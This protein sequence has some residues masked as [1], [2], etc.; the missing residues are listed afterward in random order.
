MSPYPNHYNDE[1]LRRNN[2]AAP[3]PKPVV[4]RAP[5]IPPSPI[6]EESK[7]LK[8]IP[9]WNVPSEVPT[10]RQPATPPA[11]EEEDPKTGEVSATDPAEDLN[12]SINTSAE[13]GEASKNTETPTTDEAPNDENSVAEEPEVQEEAPVEEVKEDPKPKKTPGR[14]KSNK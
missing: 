12:D 5:E 13:D 2:F 7:P 3:A 6:A 11:E 4:G 8:A 9:M 1:F 14:R 10:V